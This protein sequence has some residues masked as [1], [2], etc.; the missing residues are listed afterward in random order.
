MYPPCRVASRLHL[1]FAGFDKVLMEDC[2]KMIGIPF[3]S[4]YLQLIPNRICC[5]NEEQAPRFVDEL[6]PSPR[7]ER[8]SNLESLKQALWFRVFQGFFLGS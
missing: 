4:I 2:T 6:H 8:R 3:S 1:R 5:C 7:S